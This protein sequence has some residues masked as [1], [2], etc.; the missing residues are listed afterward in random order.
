VNTEPVALSSTVPTSFPPGPE[1]ERDGVDFWYRGQSGRRMKMEDG[2]F[3]AWELT[4]C[5][6]QAL[7]NQEHPV[8]K[9]VAFF[10]GLRNRIE[11][12]YEQRLEPVIAGKAQSLIM[13]FEQFLVKRRPRRANRRPHRSRVFHRP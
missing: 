5:I 13:N 4:R 6:R 12:K 9:N 7:P 8:R 10:I 3:K 1:G 2:A 11:H